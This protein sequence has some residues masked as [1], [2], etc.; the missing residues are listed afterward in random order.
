MVSPVAAP[1]QPL[2]LHGDAR[3]AES[4]VHPV[5]LRYLEALVIGSL[6]IG[7]VG[8]VVD[9]ML[10]IAMPR[11]ALWVQV[12]E[13]TTPSEAAAAAAVAAV[14][15][16]ESSEIG[17]ALPVNCNALHWGV[18]VTLWLQIICHVAQVAHAAMVIVEVQH[19]FHAKRLVQP[20]NAE[21]HTTHS[22]EV[23]RL[24]L[25]VLRPCQLA[26]RCAGG[27]IG[28]LLAVAFL[29]IAQRH[30]AA[31]LDLSTD[32][33]KARKGWATVTAQAMGVVSLLDLWW[34]LMYAV[35]AY[36]YWKGGWCLRMCGLW[37]KG[38]G[39]IVIS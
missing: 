22:R 14:K 39:F 31:C 18:E 21:E 13:D 9:T 15:R 25:A 26:W 5:R 34:V 27:I 30:A 3:V 6:V 11:L 23:R 33:G 36:T 17:E 24:Q 32:V 1:R 10:L 16:P 37:G 12:V 29:R 8:A 38:T 7:G 4:K 19:A 28:L 35:G 2:T 20:V